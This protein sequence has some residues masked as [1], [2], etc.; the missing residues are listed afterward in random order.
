MTQY[1]KLQT[2]NKKIYSKLGGSRC[3]IPKRSK[4]S[5]NI[6]S[7]SRV[8]VVRPIK[9]ASVAQGLFLRWVQAQ[10]RS[11]DAPGIPKNA[12]GPIG[13]PLKMFISTT[14]NHARPKCVPYSESSKLNHSQKCLE[15]RHHSPKKGHLK[16]RTVAQK[17]SAFPKTPQAQSA[18]PKKGHLKRQVINLTPTRRLKSWRDG[19]LRIEI[20][21]VA[22]HTR[23][24]PCC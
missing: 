16:C 9:R 12:P 1:N 3:G 21:P 7:L 10:D 24:D 20:C 18:F 6:I 2:I 22:R 11:R 19:P 5:L 17:R 15:P 13:I 14:Q 23:P 4:I 8:F